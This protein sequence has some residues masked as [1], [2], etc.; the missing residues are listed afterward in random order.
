MPFYVLKL[1]I[2][3]AKWIIHSSTIELRPWYIFWLGKSLLLHA[4]TETDKTGSSYYGEQSLYFLSDEG[5][6]IHVTLGKSCILVE[7]F[8]E[9]QLFF[10][11]DIFT[12]NIFIYIAKPGP[13][14]SVEWS[15]NG[16][17]FCVVYGCIRFFFAKSD[18]ASVSII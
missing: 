16:R 15:P 12:K 5:D 8:K 7:Y 9:I 6:S 10:I 4:S 13:I 2:G 18:R 17:E 1:I 11:L 3:Y 14:Y